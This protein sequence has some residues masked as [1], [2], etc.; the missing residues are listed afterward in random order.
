[1]SHHLLPRGTGQCLAI[2]SVA[3]C[4][5]VVPVWGGET[6]TVLEVID[7]DT[8]RVDLNG[9]IE[10]VRLIGVDT[11]ETVHPQKPVERFEKEASAFTTLLALHRVV[12]LEADPHSNR[13]KYGRLLRYVYLPDGKL[14]NA[15]IIAHG[16]GHAYTRFPFE[17]IEEFR[18]LERQARQESRGLWADSETL[19]PSIVA[20]SPG[21][22][23]ETVYVTRTG[24]KYHRGDCRHV[25]RS[26][27]PITLADAVRR[28]EPC[29]VCDAPRLA[30]SDTPVRGRAG[31][32]EASTDA[33]GLPQAGSPQGD[34]ADPVVYVTRT[35]SKYHRAGCR[36]LGKSQIPLKLS[37]ASK[38]YNPCSIC[39]PPVRGTRSKR[40]SL[41]TPE[42]TVA[43]H[44]GVMESDLAGG[45]E[46]DP[47]S[48]RA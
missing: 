20:P 6:G 36:H 33:K 31:G 46:L 40:E 23:G 1:M 35:G 24:T 3:A 27:I 38:R 43:R 28:Y 25:A 26:S 42:E 16:Y 32:E 21:S 48:T 8:L 7:G 44:A 18:S 12:R 30:A 14:L 10:R 17:K 9:E 34:T 29:S 45:G 39:R 15:E 41:Q 47:H 13:D 37:K 5:A 2:A 4:L 22:S 19:V 11:P